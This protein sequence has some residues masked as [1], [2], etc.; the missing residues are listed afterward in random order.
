MFVLLLVLPVEL[1]VK[2]VNLL[3]SLTFALFNQN[4]SLDFIGVYRTFNDWFN[5]E[6]PNDSYFIAGIYSGS[7]VVNLK[8]IISIFLLALFIH[9]TVFLVLRRFDT[10]FKCRGKNIWTKNISKLSKTQLYF[11]Y[12]FGA[13]MILCLSSFSE[14]FRLGGHQTSAEIYS[15]FIATSI[16]IFAIMAVIFTLVACLMTVYT[17]GNFLHKGLFQGLRNHKYAK[18]SP[19]LFLL[20]RIVI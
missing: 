4:S 16:V 19:F 3:K 7:S 1:P 8:F 15:V 14:V 20:R 2:I 18:L 11:G 9:L 6:Q 17:Q 5:I 10:T 13:F 12:L